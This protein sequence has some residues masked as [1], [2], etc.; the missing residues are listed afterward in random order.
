[1]GGGRHATAGAQIGGNDDRRAGE[2]AAAEGR[3]S[4]G[5]V[6]FVASETVVAGPHRIRVRCG[7]ARWRD[8]ASDVA[9]VYLVRRLETA[10]RAR[11]LC[12]ARA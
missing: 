4:C 10:V 8:D 2:T 11:V 12:A 5:S 7:V 1:M 3:V 9:V 6:C